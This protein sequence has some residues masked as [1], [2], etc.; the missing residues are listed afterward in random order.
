MMQY[1]VA[2]SDIKPGNPP[3][4]ITEWD[5]FGYYAYLPAIFIYHDVSGLKWLP[6]I[7]KKY[8]VTGGNGIQ[9]IKLDNGN[10]TFKYLGGVA[11]LE[12]PFFFIGHWIALHSAYPADGFSPPYQYSVTFGVILYCIAG[13]FLLRKI[14]LLF[15][16][17]LTTGITLLAVCLATNFIE[18]AAI[19]NGQSHTFIFPLYILVLYTTIQWHKKPT[20]GLAALTGYITGLATICRPTEAI[21]LF[22]PLLWN[23]HTKEAAKQKWQLVKAHKNQIV[24]AAVFGLL[25]ILPQLIYW[26]ITTGSFIFD[27]GSSWDFLTP[28]FR[29]LCGWEKGWFIYTPVT[30]FFIVGLF[31]IKKYPF[32]KSVVWFCLLNIYI[33]IGWRDWHYGGSYST[34]ALMQSYP[35]FALP[36]AAF[37][38]NI[39]LK[40][41][42]WLFYLLCVYLIVV[43]LFQI[44]QYRRTIIHYDDMNRA[45]YFRVYLNPNPTPIDMSLLDDDEIINDESKYRQH[46][47]IAI[48]STSSI[49]FPASASGLL[50]EAEMN[51]LIPI[52]EAKERWLKI[53]CKIK[54]PGYLWLSYLNAELKAG[55]SVK[56]TKIRL[57]SP[58]SI[59]DEANDYAFYMRIPAYFDTG[60][61][62]LYISSPFSFTGFAE[63][64]NITELER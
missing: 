19:E 46:N 17:D 64:I 47:I 18:Y 43:N 36:F 21:M 7:D 44:T 31:F 51:R 57:F 60:H 59:N 8:G 25:G 37:V 55:D 30:V 34:R 56:H 20:A 13:I 62:R 14:L 1:R 42:R 45:Y 6:A 10:Y 40:K 26:K 24:Y 32:R 28:H 23:T 63:K 58:L 22:I 38:E 35:V 3:L 41:W 33:I 9:A 11:M 2:Y 61:F 5:A 39:K 29:V 4:K 50:Y 53:A 27:V 52:G 12:A 54:A 15:F 49:T 16:S 48:D